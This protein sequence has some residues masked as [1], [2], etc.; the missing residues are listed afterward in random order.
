MLELNSI[1]CA[2]WNGVVPHKSLL[3]KIGL[4]ASGATGM[5]DTNLLRGDRNFCFMMPRLIFSS[6]C[7]ALVYH[8]GWCLFHLAL[9]N[10]KDCP[11]SPLASTCCG[12]TGGG[13]IFEFTPGREFF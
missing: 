4:W 1:S 2:L 5:R 9:S 7:L 13:Q 8:G 11:N 10:L 3:R 6:M 12:L